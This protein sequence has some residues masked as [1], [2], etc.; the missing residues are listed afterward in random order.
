MIRSKR[1]LHNIHITPSM[2]LLRFSEV[3][4]ECL[5]KVK[6][7]ILTPSGVPKI[8]LDLYLVDANIPVLLCMYVINIE[9]LA[10]GTS[11]NTLTSRKIIGSRDGKKVFFTVSLYLCVEKNV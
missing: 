5:R 10:D 2:N 3:S 8:I 4:F 7:P 9:N 1:V 6:I 11:V